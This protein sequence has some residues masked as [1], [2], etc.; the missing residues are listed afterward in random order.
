MLTFLCA[1]QNI[2]KAK[3]EIARLEAEGDETNNTANGD[4]KEV[5][6]AAASL[7]ETTIKDDKA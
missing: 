6:E 2:E 3:K 1:R 5:D 4:S 7:K